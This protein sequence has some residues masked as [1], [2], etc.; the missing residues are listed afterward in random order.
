VAGSE[1]LV[2]RLEPKAHTAMSMRRPLLVFIKFFGLLVPFLMALATSPANARADAPLAGL[3]IVMMHGKGGNPDRVIDGLVAAL[4]AQGA[5]VIAPRMPWTGKNGRPDSY[6][7][8]YQ[9]AVAEVDRHVTAL[10]GEGLSRIVVA[11]QSL[12]ANVAI[13][14]AAKHGRGLVGVM[15]IAP[16]H[17]P[18][19]M[20]KGILD[21]GL[22]KAR[23]LRAAGKGAQPIQLPDFNQGPT[24]E[25][26]ATPDAYVTFFDPAGPAVIPKNAAAMPAMPFLWVI[27][28]DDKLLRAGPKYAFEMAPRH[29]K[30]RYVVVP[31]NHRDTPNSARGPIIEWLKSL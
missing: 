20:N 2:D 15:A 25:V 21:E 8:T 27:G 11:G 9:D 3:G 10:R 24:F 22:A 31:G 30:S 18:D 16:G 26:R 5:K 17:T 12:G 29:P 7:T 19:R 13:G 28:Q 1:D 14:Y 6:E 4:R 23:R